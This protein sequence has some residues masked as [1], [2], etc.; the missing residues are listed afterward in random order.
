MSTDA[1][2]RAVPYTTA[3]SLVNATQSTVS[4][5]ATNLR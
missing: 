2:C 3:E 5:E 1:E 4:L